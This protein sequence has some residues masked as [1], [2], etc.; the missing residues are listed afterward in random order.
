V[1]L[2]WAAMIHYRDRNTKLN[3]DADIQTKVNLKLILNKWKPPAEHREAASAQVRK[4]G[5]KQHISM[6]PSM[7]CLL[8]TEP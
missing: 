1:T 5:A 3:Q 4:V 6:H 2:G 8:R 7:V